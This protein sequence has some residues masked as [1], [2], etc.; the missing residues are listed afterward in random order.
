MV[1][2]RLDDLSEEKRFALI[3]KAGYWKGVGDGS[4][5]GEGSSLAATENI[6]REL[7]G[8][9]RRLEIRSMLDVPC[10]DWFWM[11]RVELGEIAYIGGDIVADMVRDNQRK[12]GARNREFRRIDLAS[13]DLP[14]VDLVLVRDCLVHLE[15]ATIDQCLR[16]VVRSGATYFATT[17]FTDAT[18]NAPPLLKDRW[19]PLNM[20]L[21]PYSFSAPLALLDDSAPGIPVDA[22]KRLG[23]WRV[24]DIAPLLPPVPGQLT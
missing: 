13:D 3:Y 9:L 20:L 14:H 16:N 12:F 6:R 10:G 22:H 2:R 19:R 21:P 23:V 5:S 7:P 8:L 4:L 24:G 17:T 11:S 18:E 15:P 1:E